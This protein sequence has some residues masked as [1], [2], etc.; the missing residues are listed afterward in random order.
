MR[1][2]DAHRPAIGGAQSLE[3]L[4]Q[5][6]DGPAGQVA[7]NERALQIFVAEAVVRGIEFG[8]IGGLSSQRIDR[9]DAVASSPIGVDK[10]QDAGVLLR[11]LSVEG[12]DLPRGDRFELRLG[13][14]RGLEGRLAQVARRLEQLSPARVNGGRV[15]LV[16][17]ADLLDEGGVHAEA[18]E[19]LRDRLLVLRP[20]CF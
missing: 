18:L 14:R 9:G 3:D 10:A 15:D 12:R 6:L 19:D 8:E 20:A 17:L 7:G 1:E 16:A 4:A 5:R 11:F 13:R 2:L